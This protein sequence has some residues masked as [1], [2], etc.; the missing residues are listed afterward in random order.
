ME[1]GLAEGE[2]IHTHML[3]SSKITGPY[4]I[5]I[6]DHTHYLSLLYSHTRLTFSPFFLAN[7]KLIIHTHNTHLAVSV[8]IFSVV[9]VVAVVDC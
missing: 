9:V 5:V 8:F 1:I 2:P 6:L 7:E 3:M 4:F